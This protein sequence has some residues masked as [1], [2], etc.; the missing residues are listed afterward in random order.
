MG[1]PKG[2]TNDRAAQRA[3]GNLAWLLRAHF[4]ERLI[5]DWYLMILQGKNPKIVEDARCKETGGYRVDEDRDVLGAPSPE[6]RDAA[7]RE[8]LNRRD[9]LPMQA[10]Q[11]KA[12]LQTLQLTGTVS[13]SELASLSPAALGRVIASLQGAIAE[14]RALPAG[15]VDQEDAV[16]LVDGPPT[17]AVP[18]AS[19]L[20]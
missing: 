6:R 4:H 17:N 5:F 9:G 12:E 19:R 3:A 2:S 16:E 8:L 14:T 7:M 11:L 18:A 15:T 10:F 20:A 1:R 13:A